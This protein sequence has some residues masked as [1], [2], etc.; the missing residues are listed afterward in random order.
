M[1]IVMYGD[2]ITDAGRTWKK[3]FDVNDYGAGYVSLVAKKLLKEEN[4]Y[5]IYNRGIS[6]NKIV[7]L[8]ARIKADVWNLSP[9]VLSIL[10]G[11]NDVWHEIQEEN[12]VD[13][14]RFERMYRMLIGDTKK[15]LPNVKIMLMEPFVLK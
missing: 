3:D 13:L 1:K 11:V 8:Y 10:V 4:A 12:G 9:D 14:E 7:D 15:R 5:Q 2:S 6:G